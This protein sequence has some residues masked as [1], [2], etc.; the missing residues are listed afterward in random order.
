MSAPHPI[1]AQLAA[2]R[3][4]HQITLKDT[5]AHA[6]YALNTIYRWEKGLNVPDLDGLT[7]YAAA[8]G[9]DITLTPKGDPKQ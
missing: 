4:A 8:L 7:D 5:A 1:I 3:R 6:G 2:H 9:Y